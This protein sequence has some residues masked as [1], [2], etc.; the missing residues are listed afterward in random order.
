MIQKN[1]S[2]SIGTCLENIS[3]VHKEA[4]IQGLVGLGWVGL[5]IKDWCL[6]KGGGGVGE[7]EKD[8]G[9]IAPPIGPKSSIN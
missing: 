9:E 7:I 8:E 4:K 1:I 6:E 3:R 2:T 5:G